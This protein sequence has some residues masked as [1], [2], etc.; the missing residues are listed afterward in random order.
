MDSKDALSPLRQG[1]RSAARVVD[2]EIIQEPPERWM[3]QV[4]LCPLESWVYMRTRTDPSLFRCIAVVDQI[5]KRVSTSC[6]CL[7]VDLGRL[8][9]LVCRQEP[10]VRLQARPRKSPRDRLYHKEAYTYTHP[11]SGYP[12]LQEIE[13]A[14]ASSHSPLGT[15]NRRQLA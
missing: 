10:P 14:I 1:L 6:A 13:T 9:F 4:V 3:K 7:M 12:G 11:R 15:S 2:E 5:T 8:I